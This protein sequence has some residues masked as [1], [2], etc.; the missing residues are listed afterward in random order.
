M[1]LSC[2]IYTKEERNVA[3]INIPND[4]IQT[5]IENEKDLAIISIRGVL[6]YMLLDTAPDVYGPYMITDRKGNNQLI[7][8]CMNEIYGTILASLLCYCKFLMMLKLNELKM[9]PYDRCVA[10]LLV[11][12][13]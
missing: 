10:N 13:F 1:L 6:V 4:F 2:I 3:V 5:Q 11:N 8:K 12:G 7:N 9:N